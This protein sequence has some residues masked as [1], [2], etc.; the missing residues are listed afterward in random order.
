MKPVFNETAWTQVW[1][2]SPAS[3]DKIQCPV[4][5]NSKILAVLITSPT[6][7]ENEWYRA[8]FIQRE[9]RSGLIV[10]GSND[11]RLDASRRLYLNRLQIFTYN[12]DIEYALTAS[13][14]IYGNGVNLFAWEYTGLIE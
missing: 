14:Q 2:I 11:A 10:G 4:L 9:V 12:V 7:K 8:A 6:I 13:C 3:K 1:N 5:L